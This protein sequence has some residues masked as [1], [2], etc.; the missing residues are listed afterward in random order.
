MM[1]SATLSKEIRGVCRK[2]MQNP[3]E[4]FIDD[5]TKLRLHGLQQ[6]FIKLEEKEK[7]RKLSDLLDALVFNQVI[8]F[9]RS[10]NRAIVLN[11]L[12]VDS[13]FPSVCIHGNLSQEE[14]YP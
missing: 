2:F 3:F 11:N 9:V 7:N 1:F 8:I 14:R 13:N 12:L 4:V 6:Y 10:V 5:E